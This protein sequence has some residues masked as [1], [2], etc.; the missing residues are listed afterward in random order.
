MFTYRRILNISISLHNRRK[1]EHSGELPHPKRVSQQQT[2]S[3]LLGQE[4]QPH[5]PGFDHHAAPQ[6]FVLTLFPVF[7]PKYSDYLLCLT[8]T[9]STIPLP[10]TAWGPANLVSCTQNHLLHS[11]N[12]D[13]NNN[14]NN[15]K[16]TNQKNHF[17]PLW[18]VF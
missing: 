15:D 11:Q 17:K 1:L 7:L 9:S 8:V 16:Q 3:A 6:H 18:F 5:C 2:G 4:S 14:N 13:K 10:V 12:V